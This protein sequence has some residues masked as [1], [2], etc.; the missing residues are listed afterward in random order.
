MPCDNGVVRVLTFTLVA[1]SV[2]FALRIKATKKDGG[3][4][5]G[6]DQRTAARKLEVETGSPGNAGL[7]NAIRLGELSAAVAH[8]FNK[9]LTIM[10]GYSE[11]LLADLSSDDAVRPFVEEINLA[12]YRAARLTRHLLDF[13]HVHKPKPELLNLNSVVQGMDDL[14]R[15]LIGAGVDLVR[16]LTPSIQAVR[17]DR[18]HLDQLLATLVLIVR[19]G[20]PTGGCVTIETSNVILA[21]AL[22]VADVEIP[23]GAYVCIGV[24]DHCAGANTRPCPEAPSPTGPGLRLVRQLVRQNGGYFVVDELPKEGRT[25]RVYL[26]SADGP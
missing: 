14:L 20:A 1:G 21:R 19:D 2:P 22:R 8:D 7:H 26:P 12:V 16:D 11:L 25:F 24:R 13:G 4:S 17:F 5:I 10:L 9:L 23:S 6:D 18:G 15:G 3:M